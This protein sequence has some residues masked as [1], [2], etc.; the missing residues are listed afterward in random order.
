MKQG[1][2]LV[3]LL[4]VV[5]LL[6]IFAAVVVVNLQGAD[7]AAGVPAAR[8]VIS[9]EIEIYRQLNLVRLDRSA[10]SCPLPLRRPVVVMSAVYPAYQSGL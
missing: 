3:E 9:K 10:G 1:F 5:V 4:A 6:A 8:Q 7:K 2:T